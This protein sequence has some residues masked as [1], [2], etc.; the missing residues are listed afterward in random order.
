MGTD[1]NCTKTKM[2][3]VTKLHEGTKLKENKIARKHKIARS[4]ICTKQKLHEGTK[5]HEGTKMREDDFTP[6]V[7]FAQ[8]TFLHVSKTIIKRLKQKKKTEKKSI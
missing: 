3:E 7:N 1:P 2:H 5:W 8:V 4:Q 6:W